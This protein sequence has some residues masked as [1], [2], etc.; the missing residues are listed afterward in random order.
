MYEVSECECASV[1]LPLEQLLS[2]CALTL[3]RYHE[4]NL[5]IGY[6]I[7]VF[8]TAVALAIGY[9]SIFQNGVASDTLFSRILVTTRNPTLDRLSVGACLGSDPFPVELKRTKLRFGVLLEDEYEGVGGAWE[10]GRGR[11][12]TMGQRSPS[13]GVGTP[14]FGERGIEHCTFGAEGEI[15]RIE[16]YGAYAGLKHY[17]DEA[18]AFGGEEELPLL[19]EAGEDEDEDD[20]MFYDV[21]E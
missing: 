10:G 4:E 5:W 12:S 15:K 13:L 20:E 1:S 11:R 17:R 2:P 16:K 19:R 6:A 3:S 14:R 9:I 18:F 8:V 7:V 21:D